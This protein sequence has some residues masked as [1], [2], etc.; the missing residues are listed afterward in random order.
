MSEQRPA[1][2]PFADFQTAANLCNALVLAESIDAAAVNALCSEALGADFAE[3]LAPDE[4]KRRA[5]IEP[6]L[7][8]A[9]TQGSVQTTTDRLA[10]RVDPSGSLLWAQWHS[11]VNGDVVARFSGLA[12]LMSDALNVRGNLA[13][14]HADLQTLEGKARSQAEII[15]HIH[16]SVIVMDLSGFICSWN[17]GAELLFGYTAS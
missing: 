8:A 11:G 10:H 17:K 9:L 6:L 13:T 1:A 16:D 12:R 2:F 15:D 5:L 14:R 7:H 4:A 3:W